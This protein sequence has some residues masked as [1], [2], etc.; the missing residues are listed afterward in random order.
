MPY[1]SSKEPLWWGGTDFLDQYIGTDASTHTG[2]HMV[3]PIHLAAHYGTGMDPMRPEMVL[4]KW[5]SGKPESRKHE[6]GGKRL[7]PILTNPMDDG[8]V[9][10]YRCGVVGCRGAWWFESALRDHQ[11]E[12]PHTMIEGELPEYLPPVGVYGASCGSMYP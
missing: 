6:L 3:P 9:A 2:L 8:E 10:N 7:G 12:M 5:I 1:D 11:N 4:K